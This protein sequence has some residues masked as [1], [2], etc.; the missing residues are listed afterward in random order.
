MYSRLSL[1]HSLSIC[2]AW[3]G[4]RLL[5]AVLVAATVAES[6]GFAHAQGTTATV[7]GTVTDNS[8]A[9][10]PDAAVQLKNI[11]VGDLRTTQSNSSGAFVFSAVPSGDYALTIRAKGFNTFEQTGIHLDPGDQRAIREIRLTVG[12]SESVTVTSATAQ[13]NLDSGEISSTISAQDIEHLAVEGRDVTELLKILPGM[14]INPGQFPSPENRSYDP[15]IVNFT[16]ALGAYSGNGTPNN[17][18]SLLTDGADITDPGS[19]GIAIQNVNYDQVAEVKVQTGSFTADTARG[20]VVINAIGKSGGN[21]YHG[22]LYAYARTSQLNSVDWIANYTAQGKPPDRQVYPGATLGGPVLIPGTNF[23]HNR[24]L[25]FFV[26]GEDYAQRNVYA[27]GGASTAILGAIVPTAGMR[28]GDFSTTQLAQYLGSFY[29]PVMANG[30][31]SNSYGNVCAVPQTGPQGQTIINGNIAP[32]M[33]AESKLVFSQMPLPNLSGAARTGAYNYI[34]TNLVDNNLYQARGRMDYAISDR[35]KLF[36]TYSVEKGT[37]YEPNGIYSYIP[38]VPFGNVNT[39]GG[40]EVSSLGSHV[41]SLNFTSVISPS[42]TNEFYAAGAY[43]SQRFSARNPAANSKSSAVA[44]SGNPYTGLFNNGSQALVSV[45]DYGYNGLPFNTPFD[46]TYGGYYANKQIRTAGDNITKL[47]KQHTLRAG[48]FYQWASNPQ[49]QQVNT[50]GSVAN[51]FMPSSFTDP[52][53]GNTY[54]TDGN[55]ISGNYLANFAEGHFGSFSQVSFQ[56]INNIYFWNLSG[57]VQDHWAITSHLSIDLGVRLEHLTPWIDAHG[58][59]IAVFDSADYTATAAAASGSTNMSNHQP[60]IVYHATNPSIPLSGITLPAVFVE[61]RGGFAWDPF[62]NGHTTLRGGAGVYRQHDSYNDVQNPLNTAVGL[63]NYTSPSSGTLATVYGFQ[64]ALAGQA[65][66]FTADQSVN[67]L[68]KGDHQQPVIYTYNLAVDQQL[69]HGI[70]FEIAYAGNHSQRLLNTFGPDNINALTVGSLYKPQPNSRPDTAST[71]GTIFPIFSPAGATGNNT[72]FQNLTQ[73]VIDSYRPYPLYNAVDAQSH[74]AFANYNGLQT[75]I[76]ENGR[77]GRVGAN[78]TWSKALGAIAGGDPTNI[79]NDYNLVNFSRAHIFNLTYAAYSNNF[80]HNRALALGGNGWEVSGYVGYQSGPNMPA[81]YSNNFALGGTLTLPTGS[82]ATI[83]GQNPSVC[84][85]SP[86]TLGVGS[87]SFLGTPDV[88]LQPTVVGSLRGKGGHNFASARAFGLPGLGTNGTYHFGYLPGPAFFDTDISAT[89]HFKV[90]E[91]DSLSLRFSGFNFLNHPVV[92]F[93]SLD[94][95][96][97][98]LN[99]T[100]T[101]NG[102]SA[103]GAIASATNNNT[104][105]GSAN[106]K[107]GRRIVEMSLRYDF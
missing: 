73:P 55:G 28:N 3:C 56:P 15:S 50:Q 62:G 93:S 48:I 76:S 4:S 18:T 107:A 8:G 53:L 27:Y 89:R 29:Q 57:F 41:A 105:F 86:C 77:F 5:F 100:G 30:Q 25:T 69:P 13:L 96:A 97:Y 91:H 10:L 16:G 82:T 75:Q 72:S 43:F 39:P 66:H 70:V 31:C 101:V 67:A 106:F 81:I 38:S 65:S 14:A 19:Y 103:N 49:S 52:I 90:T 60:G 20:P 58:I 98:T 26:A 21:K 61:P 42:L 11:V 94:P 104:N 17:A 47:I 59:G 12:A 74:S 32:Y 7:G 45:G 79:R 88:S 22:S 23:N 34:T 78:Y 44:A 54:N 40:G 1:R 9:V 24:K 35:N 63:L 80:F 33:D 6:T 87:T 51:Y 37:A 95:S 64:S 83:P 92:S 71:A 85:T 36:G 102:S 46:F 68:L 84:S 2:L 99:Y